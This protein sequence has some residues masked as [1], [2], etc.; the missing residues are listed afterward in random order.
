M[1][2]LLIADPVAAATFVTGELRHLA[3]EPY[4]DLRRTA[5]AYLEHGQ[6]TTAAAAT[7]GVHRNTVMRRLART[8][9]L[10]GRDLV[11]R[12]TETL[13]ALSLCEVGLGRHAHPVT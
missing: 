11:R 4:S 7:L 3:E 2:N 6:D 12:P 13:V 5:R 9:D 10:L 8:N 1:L